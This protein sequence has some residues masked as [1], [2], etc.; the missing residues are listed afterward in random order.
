MES[1]SYSLLFQSLNNFLKFFSRTTKLFEDIEDFES[2]TNE[3]ILNNLDKF[4]L[5]KYYHKCTGG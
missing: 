2:E 4:N 3:K 5:T 1:Y